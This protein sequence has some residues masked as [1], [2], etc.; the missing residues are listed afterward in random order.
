VAR[1][2]CVC[3]VENRLDALSRIKDMFLATELPGIEKTVLKNAEKPL[4][5]VAAQNRY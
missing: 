2:L 1:A 3:G 5:V 4:P